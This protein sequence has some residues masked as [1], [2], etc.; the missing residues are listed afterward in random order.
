MNLFLII[1]DLFEQV[2]ESQFGFFDAILNNLDVDNNMLL[3][4]NAQAEAV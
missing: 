4:F 3:T 1:F 2:L